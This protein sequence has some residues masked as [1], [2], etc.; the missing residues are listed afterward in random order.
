MIIVKK[1]FRQIFA[2]LASLQ[3]AVFL[4][5]SLAVILAAGTVVES[6]HDT[7]T[8]G[9]YVYRTW[10]FAAFL[11]LLGTNVF[12]AGMSRYPWKRHHTGFLVVHVGILTIL[13]GSLITLFRG[14]EGQL[15]IP[16]G[17]SRERIFLTES[18]LYFYD[19]DKGSLEELPAQFRFNP[20]S[21]ERPQGGKVFGDILV[22]VVEYLPNALMEEEVHDGFDQVNPAMQLVLSGQRANLNEWVFARDYTR[23]ALELGPAQVS[24]VELPNK[25]ELGAILSDEKLRGPVLWVQGKWI[26]LKGNLGEEFEIAGKKFIIKNFLPHGAVY[27]GSLVNLSDEPINP[28]AVLGALG[29]QEKD[30]HLFS[31]FPE[32]GHGLPGETSVSTAMRL[33]WIPEALGRKDNEMVLAK[34]DQGAAYVTVKAG[35]KW[36]KIQALPIGVEQ[37]TGW[38][39]F[40]FK[41]VEVR[42]RAKVVKKY[43]RASV[44]KGK[45]GPPPAVHLQIARGSAMED[46]WLGRGQSENL[47]LGDKN[48]K[49]AFALKSMPLGFSVKL[50]DFRMGTYE[51]TQDPASYESLVQVHDAD[52]PGG[53][54][55]LI[56]MNQPLEKNKFKLFQASYQ[57]N[58]DGS[59]WTVLSV[60]YDPGIAVKYVGSIILILGIMT[61]FYFRKVY[62][63]APVGQRLKAKWKGTAY[64]AGKLAEETR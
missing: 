5:I 28:V 55:H 46:I 2:F 17:E 12:C 32:L 16:E 41:V 22:R 13:A 29:E 52:L 27:Q 64:P 34:D 25:N 51:G 57:L 33:I 11:G 1:I 24:F 18:A 36:G 3:L 59:A 38:M 30:I 39:D 8:A 37:P 50:K 7:T 48:I 26:P 42:S 35:G 47:S 14:F 56:A 60:A 43:R 10:W 61:I 49:T 31:K 21:P 62:L 63:G 45:E 44:P 4:L 19:R 40:K 15:I 9:H 58:P 23:Q 6:L 53:F 20:P 54:E